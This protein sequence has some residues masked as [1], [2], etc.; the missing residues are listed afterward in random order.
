MSC[1][2]GAIL[3][4]DPLGIDLAVF[5]TA[6]ARSGEIGVARSPPRR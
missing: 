6:P 2:V 5:G 1:G 3:L 4:D